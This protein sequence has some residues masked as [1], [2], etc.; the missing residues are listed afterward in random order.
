MKATI[1]IPDEL[2]RRVKA[3]SALEGRSLRAVAVQLF[4]TWIRSAA[5]PSSSPP[6]PTAE[7]IERFPWLAVSR[8]YPSSG[9]SHD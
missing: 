4:E 1:E 5:P 9:L 7:E 3:R 8:R 2:Y 6:P